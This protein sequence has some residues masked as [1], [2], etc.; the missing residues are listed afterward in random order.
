MLLATLVRRPKA[1]SIGWGVLQLAAHHGVLTRDL[2]SLL[3][4]AQMLLCLLLALQ[5]IQELV[6]G[7]GNRRRRACEADG[8][9]DAVSVALTCALTP[10][11]I[12]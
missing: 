10:R 8:S 12:A 9:G 11:V 2:D 7:L 3:A 5:C 6:L 4:E 1:I